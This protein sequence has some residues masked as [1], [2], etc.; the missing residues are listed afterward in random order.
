MPDQPI[1]F[2]NRHSG[3]LETEHV[4][5]E[6]FLRWVY[7]TPLGKLALHAVV[8]RSMFSRLYGWLMDS[9]RSRGLIAPF[10]ARYGLDV[11]EFARAPESF[12]SFNE[13]FHRKLRPG[14]RPVDPDQR[15]I[16]FPA[17][18]RH[19]AVPD[20]SAMTGLFVKGQRF[21]LDALLEDPTLAARY[22]SGTLVLSRL[23]PVDYHRFHFPVAGVPGE[24][25]VLAGALASVSPLALRNRLEILW[26]N[27]RVVTR[28]ETSD[29]GLVILIE[30]GATNVGSI[31]QRFRPGAPVAKGA[32]KGYFRFGGSSLITLFEAG[33]VQLAPDLLRESAQHRELYAWVGEPMG[34]QA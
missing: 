22:A 25:R 9:E 21:D 2:F 28:L 4:Y 32:E 12:S 16:V 11:A 5:G 26:Q 10:I 23:C 7:G 27:K 33:R 17:D 8:K 14:A 15:A 24:P 18:G 20:L 13:F 34:L 3:R 1:E 19:L 30:I 29:V 31:V 6:P